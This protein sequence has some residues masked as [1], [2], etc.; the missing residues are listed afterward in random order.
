MSLCFILKD[1][2]FHIKFLPFEKKKKSDS[3][4]DL[5]LFKIIFLNFLI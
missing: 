5:S 2:S 3:L 4:K 1:Q